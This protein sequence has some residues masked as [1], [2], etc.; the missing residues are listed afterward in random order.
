MPNEVDINE[1]PERIR[2]RYE[3]YL[4]TSFFWLY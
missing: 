2:R 4:K 3:A 1:W